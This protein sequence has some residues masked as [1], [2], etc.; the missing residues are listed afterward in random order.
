MERFLAE[1]GVFPAQPTTFLSDGGETVRQAQGEFREFGEPIL[2]WFHIAMRMTQLSQAIKGL[3]A[4]LPVE[5]DS[6][7]RIEDCLREL[8]RAKAYLWHGSPHRALRTLDELTWDIGTESPRA[9]AL[10][11]KL[12]EFMNYITSNVASIPNYADRHRHGEPIAS[13]FVESA[14]NQVVSKRLVKK[15]QMRWTLQGAH[16]LLQVRARVLNQ[17]LRADFERWHP[18]LRSAAEC[19]QMA[20]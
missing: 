4:D 13:G 9:S 18:E 14:V 17:Q 11:E 20:A 7:N 10:Q 3:V 12:K 5:G 1:Q 16:R 2:D 19:S 15:Q 6:P 8:R